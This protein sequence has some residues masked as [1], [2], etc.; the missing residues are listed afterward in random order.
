M[1]DSSTGHGGQVPSTFGSSGGT[2]FAW[3]GHTE[4]VD[5]VRVVEEPGFLGVDFDVL[6]ARASPSAGDEVHGGVVEFTVGLGINH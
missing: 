5:A 3:W 1:V 6:P 4:R 2:L